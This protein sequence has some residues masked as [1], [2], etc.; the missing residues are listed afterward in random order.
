MLRASIWRPCV[1]LIWV[2][3][4]LI[5]RQVVDS[6]LRT[7]LPSFAVG[8]FILLSGICSLA[9][10]RL[11]SRDRLLLYVGIFSTLYGTRLLIENELVRDAFNRPGTGYLPWALCITYAINIPFTLFARELLGRGWKGT[12]VIWLWLSIGF[13]AIAIP[14]AF[15]APN[16]GWVSLVNSLLVVSGTVLMLVQVLVERRAG[17]SLAASLLWPLLIFGIFVLLENNGVRM[18]GHDK[19]WPAAA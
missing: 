1:S 17:N 15:F 9:L 13:A 19:H 7:S 6:A 10:A 18:G 16:L 14:T 3:P 4:D 8:C 12:I 11:R 5:S 2:N